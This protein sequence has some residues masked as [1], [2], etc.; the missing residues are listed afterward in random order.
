MTAIVAA[1]REDLEAAVEAAVRRAIEEA[2]PEAV[3]RATEPEYMTGAEVMALTGWSE[4]KLAYL[5]QRREL[6]Y[7]KRGRTVLYPREGIRAY[8]EE[9][10]VRARRGGR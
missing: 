3:R 1:T 6:P 4:R 10:R 7:V 2:L 5:R 8:L 9:G